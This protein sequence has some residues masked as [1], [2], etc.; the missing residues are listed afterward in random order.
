MDFADIVDQSEQ[1]PLYI[2]FL[3]GT[4]RKAVHPL[5]HTNVNKD[6][7]NN[8]ESS[9]VDLF[10]KSSINLRLHLVDQVRLRTHL[11]GRNLCDVFGLLKYRV[12]K[13]QAAQ[14]WR[15]A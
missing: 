15:R 7:L 14:F 12:R 1:P 11:N 4:Q 3:F 9:G 13:G 6:R 5:L 10:S 8:A 2:H